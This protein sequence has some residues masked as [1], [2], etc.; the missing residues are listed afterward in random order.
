MSYRK[1][2][3][4]ATRATMAGGRA[5]GVYPNTGLLILVFYGRV[6]IDGEYV[7]HDRSVT[8]VIL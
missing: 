1:H 7:A 4:L 8:K 5:M 6:F 3:Y 2:K